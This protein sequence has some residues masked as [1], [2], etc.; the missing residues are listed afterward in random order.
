MFLIILINWLVFI[1]YMLV[2]NLLTILNQLR[3][4]HWQ[5]RGKG[6]FAQHKALD[7]AYGEF[8]D[9]IDSFVEVFMGKYGR[10]KSKDGFTITLVNY[11]NQNSKIVYNNYGINNLFT[12]KVLRE[13]VFRYQL[14]REK[15]R[16]RISFCAGAPDR[17]NCRRHSRLSS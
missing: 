9:L 16:D 14:K 11:E 4:Y 10:I 8:S 17:F 5:T 6:S 2:T 7:K 1:E 12:I 15:C 13:I 3:I